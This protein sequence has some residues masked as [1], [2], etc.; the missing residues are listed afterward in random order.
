MGSV[1]SNII[2][3]CNCTNIEEKEEK[4]NYNEKFN[5]IDI[6]IIKLKNKIEHTSDK[7]TD[8]IHRFEDNINNKLNIVDIKIDRL[9]QKIDTKFDLIL[10]NLTQKNK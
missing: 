3:T 6:E 10:L 5:I 9:E 8:K 7:H 1:F 2:G 4:F